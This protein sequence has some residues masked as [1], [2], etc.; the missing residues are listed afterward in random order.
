MTTV[1]GTGHRPD[2]L[3]GYDAATF[4]RLVNLAAAY[5]QKHPADH[6]ISGMALGWDMALAEAAVALKIPFTAAIPFAG[7]ERM[8]PRTSQDHFRRLCD[9]AAVI[10]IVSPG[11]YAASKMQTRNIWMVNHCDTL[12]ALWNGASGGTANCLAYAKTI[13]K[14]VH[15]LWNSWNRY[16]ETA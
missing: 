15:N 5:L 9:Q 4:A 16:K 12:V 11:G 14:P 8:W 1:A 3:G 6:V 7:Q 2:K 10:E 13:D